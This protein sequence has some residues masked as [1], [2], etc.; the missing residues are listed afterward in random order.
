M[1]P[2]QPRPAG[3]TA[4]EVVKPLPLSEPA[5]ALL[6]P[7]MT[8]RQYLD[9]LI[10]VPLR[11]DALRVLALA[12]PKPE[13]V[14][15]GALCVHLGLAKPWKP[16]AEQ[17]VESAEKWVTTPTDEHRRACA[18]AAEAAGWDTAA[19][20]LAGSAW[21]SGGSLS[22]PK[23][24]PVTPRDD[25]TGQTLAGVMLLAS[26]T[27]PKTANEKQDQFIALGLQIAG[28]QVKKGEK[29]G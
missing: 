25:L 21:L 20:C 5:L 22:P 7:E 13:A 19:G 2:P 9:A 18:L 26:V 23:L 12:L 28:G 11:V 4:A 16:S 14:W 10:A 1:T 6:T 8:V 15:W 17:A 29:A 27:D 3:R 24:P